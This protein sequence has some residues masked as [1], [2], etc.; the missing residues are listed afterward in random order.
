[1]RQNATGPWLSGGEPH[2]GA[3]ARANI[4]TRAD[5]AAI[6]LY[7]FEQLLG[8]ETILQ[9]IENAAK[10]DPDKIAIKHLLSADPEVVP[11]VITYRDLTWRLRAAASLFEEISG[12]ER[13]AV[14]IILPMLPEALIA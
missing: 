3:I 7:D 4:R 2:P 8:A 1:M 14:G 12:V 5:I 13:P 11:R 6:E 9:A 10:I